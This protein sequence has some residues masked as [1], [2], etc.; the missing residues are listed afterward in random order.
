M[1]DYANPLSLLAVVVLLACRFHADPESM[2]DTCGLVA[3]S[4]CFTVFIVDCAL[5][6]ARAL[7][8]RPSLM[9]A[10]WAMVFLIIGSC[11][12]VAPHEE[13]GDEGAQDVYR[14]L[15]AA[16][17]EGGNP[18]A[19]DDSGDCLLS[20]AAALGK[21]QVVKELLAGPVPEEAL[22]DAARCAAEAD[23]VPMLSLLLEGGVRVDSPIAGSTL[24]CVASQ[25]GCRNA[26]EF[27]LDQGAD[28]NLADAEGTPPLIHAVIADNLTSVRLLVA[29]GADASRTDAQGRTAA[30]YARLSEIRNLVT[31]S[32]L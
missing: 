12:L 14:S 16:W 4:L 25:N 21:E 13:S 3:V 6:V 20:L 5:A 23:R 15:Y 29:K 22:K 28:P 27:L 11:I 17:R 7:S 1:R 31:P 24:L 9:L 18:Y 19:R 2:S 8:H 32:P 26:V 10:V 30:S